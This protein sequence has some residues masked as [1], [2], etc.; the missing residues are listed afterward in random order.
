MALNV[1]GLLLDLLFPLSAR[2]ERLRSRAADLNQHVV[3]RRDT[4]Y[5]WIISALSYDLSL[6]RDIVLL[7]K[8]HGSSFAIERMGETIAALYIKER[9]ERKIE[10]PLLIPLPLGKKRLK[11]R[12]YN[13][14]RRIAEAMLRKLGGGIE[15]IA[16]Q[17]MQRRETAPQTKLSRKERALNMHDA[18]SVMNKNLVQGRT[19]ILIDD[20]VTTGATLNDA[21]RALSDAGA[22][23]IFA[24]TFA[25]A[26]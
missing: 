16:E 10:R 6:V 13:Q 1:I 14:A 8:F 18:F 19:I 9:A 5:P 7:A 23:D 12:G 25:R 24:L 3:P 26:E 20:V 22:H 2:E 17:S 21:Y 4:N 11:E 15:L